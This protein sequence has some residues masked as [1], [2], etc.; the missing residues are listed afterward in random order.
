[1]SPPVTAQMVKELRAMTGAGPVDYN[2]ALEENG[3][4]KLAAAMK[5]HKS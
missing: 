4:T 1:M 5:V 2:K 3:S